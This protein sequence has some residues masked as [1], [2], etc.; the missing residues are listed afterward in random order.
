M[1]VDIEL[2]K[3]L[4]LSPEFEEKTVQIDGERLYRM[5]VG[6][7]RYYQN[8]A[9]FNF[10]SLTTF[11]G[12]VTPKS[13]ILDNW[14]LQKAAELGSAEKADEYVAATADYGTALHIAIADFIRNGFVDWLEFDYW[15]FD[16]LKNSGFGQ[17]SIKSAMNELKKDFAALIQ[18]FVDYNVKVIAVE[19]PVYDESL[20]IATAI[21]LIVDMN[22]KD[23]DAELNDNRLR[24]KAIINLKSGK[25]GFY[26]NHALQ[27]CGERELYNRLYGKVYGE[28]KDVYNLAPSD[29]HDAPTYKIKNQTKACN[30]LDNKFNLLHTLA[31][32]SGLLGQPT[33]K[34]PIFIG[35]T[36][37]GESPKKALKPMTFN[38]LIS[39]NAQKQLSNELSE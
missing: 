28:I 33:S 21:D 36:N 24:H 3:I 25:K 13:E 5:S 26:E 31:K 27:L 4:Y 2:L 12:L 29:W 34:F 10:T 11:L 32:E 1:N 19:L 15:S 16:F 37:Y 17:D 7:R 23:S 35:R 30:G 18:F 8:K 14:R 6:S 9:G 38:E 39:Y 20:S 22:L